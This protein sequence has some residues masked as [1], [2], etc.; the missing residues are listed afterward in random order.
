MTCKGLNCHVSIIQERKD[1][2]KEKRR[3][4]KKK[5]AIS[6]ALKT[7]W[8]SSILERK[9]KTDLLSR[10]FLRFRFKFIL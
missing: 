5:K 1:R 9:L 2:Y 10:K 8:E 4:E 6:K 7:V 3:L